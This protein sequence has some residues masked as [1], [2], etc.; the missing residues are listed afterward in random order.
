M[1]VYR[2]PI[3]RILG[4]YVDHSQCRRHRQGNEYHAAGRISATQVEN[5]PDG[6]GP[7]RGAQFEQRFRAS[8]SCSVTRTAW[9]SV[10][11]AFS[12]PPPALRTAST[13][14]PPTIPARPASRPPT[15]M[16]RSITSITTVVFSADTASK[17]APPT[18]L[19]TVTVRARQPQRHHHGHAQGRPAGF[20]LDGSSFFS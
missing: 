8:T 16:R 17:P 7:M 9:R 20:R 11:P 13:S 15:A 3:G 12:A 18:R 19:P 14:R 10:S 2:F 1:G 4:V 5:Y 6:K